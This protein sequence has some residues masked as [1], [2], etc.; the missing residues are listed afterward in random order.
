MKPIKNYI[1]ESFIGKKYHF[2]CNCIIPID[3]V[4]S[5]TDYDISGN[6]VILTVINEDNKII[7]IGLNAVSLQIEEV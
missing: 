5:V 7:H 3:V 2:K 6:E 1:G 4:A